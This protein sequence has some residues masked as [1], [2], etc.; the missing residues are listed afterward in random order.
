M[1][2]AT[3]LDDYLEARPLTLAEIRERQAASESGGEVEATL[4]GRLI[5]RGHPSEVVLQAPQQTWD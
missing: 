4:D 1:G 3:E 5:K 2:K